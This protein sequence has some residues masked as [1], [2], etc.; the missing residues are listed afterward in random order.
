MSGVE[1]CPELDGR[2]DEA[3]APDAPEVIA[4]GNGAR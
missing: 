4:P 3:D 2:D 1:V